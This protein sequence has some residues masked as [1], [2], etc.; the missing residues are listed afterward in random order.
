MKNIFPKTVGGGLQK[1]GTMWTAVFVITLITGIM[2]I[3]KDTEASCFYNKTDNKD[4][5]F[6]FY[7]GWFCHND[8]KIH[9]GGHECRPGKGG[10]VHVFTPSSKGYCQ[11]DVAKH[12]WVEVHDASSKAVIESKDD[13]G[14]TTQTCVLDW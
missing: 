4:V 12:G 3:P 7:C 11:V 2:M 9:A 1:T 5:T 8:W 14:N 10:Y 6:N 13:N